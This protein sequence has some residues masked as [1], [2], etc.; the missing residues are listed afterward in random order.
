MVCTLGVQNAFPCQQAPFQQV[1]FQQVPFSHRSLLNYCRSRSRSTGSRSTP[2]PFQQVPFQCR[3]RSLPFPF[4]FSLHRSRSNK[5]RSGAVPVHCRSQGRLCQVT[6][7]SSS[8]PFWTPSHISAGALEPAREAQPAYWGTRQLG[9][10]R[11]KSGSYY[12]YYST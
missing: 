6:Y 3:S 2:F 4:P 11:G 9:E 7:R 12:Y 1:P 10:S 5:S 8:L